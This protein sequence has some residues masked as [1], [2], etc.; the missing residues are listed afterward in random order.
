MTT[1]S[2][3]G[4]DEFAAA[5]SAIDSVLQERGEVTE[6]LEDRGFDTDVVL[7]VAEY[8][9]ESDDDSPRERAI[10]RALLHGLL[11]G[12]RLGRNE[13]KVPDAHTA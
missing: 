11:I 4:L 6:I 1:V 2:R 10:R 12:E 13:S 9:E 7:F 5:S 3:Y 8:L